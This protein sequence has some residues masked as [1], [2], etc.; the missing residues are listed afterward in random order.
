MTKLFS[1]VVSKSPRRFQMEDRS[2]GK[3]NRTDSNMT[4][5]DALR[6]TD[7]TDDEVNA[8]VE[9][10]PGEEML[11]GSDQDLSIKRT[12][13]I[14]PKPTFLYGSEL[15]YLIECV[16]RDHRDLESVVAVK[17]KLKQMLIEEE[18]FSRTPLYPHVWVDNATGM[19]V[20]E[21]ETNVFSDGRYPTAHLAE[22]ARLE[23]CNACL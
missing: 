15:K 9:L 3:V 21:D 14:R 7:F 6:M 4:L 2:G 20:W 13:G 19:F 23:Y 18:P 10:K 22:H 8:I 5:Q 17:Q 1:P 11:F 16:S 12:D